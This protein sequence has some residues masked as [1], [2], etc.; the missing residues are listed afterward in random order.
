MAPVVLDVRASVTPVE[1]NTIQ[2]TTPTLNVLPACGAESV[3]ETGSAL[4]LAV[5]GSGH[6]SGCERACAYQGEQTICTTA[7]TQ[8]SFT[9]ALSSE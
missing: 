5:A 2:P 8:G 4:R 6:G 3:L 7:T 1:G 9:A